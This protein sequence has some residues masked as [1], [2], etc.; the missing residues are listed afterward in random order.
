M[1]NQ[2]S[3]GLRRA[4]NHAKICGQETT[5]G[6]KN[7]KSLGAEG[8]TQTPYRLAW[9]V[10]TLHA[11]LKTCRHNEFTGVPT[12]ITQPLFPRYIFAKFN[13][14]K[15]IENPVYARSSQR[16]LFRR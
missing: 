7:F 2:W 8:E 10:E 15:V 6:N 11:K 5:V 1:T 14:V 13:A 16:S 9:G 3:I 12:Y 4:R